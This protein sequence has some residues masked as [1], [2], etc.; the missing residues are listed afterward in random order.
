MRY[1]PL[2]KSE[3][4][5]IGTGHTVV[6]T[7]WTPKEAIAKK[8]DPEEYAAIGQ[9]YSPTRGINFLIRNLIYNPQVRYLVVLN[10]TKADANAGG[11]RSLLDFFCQGFSEGV[12]D[13]GKPCWVIQPRM[14]GFIDI[15]V[16]Y[17]VLIQLRKSIDLKECGDIKDAI[18]TVKEFSGYTSP[19]PWITPQQYPISEVKNS[20]LPGDRYGHRIE[21]STIAEAW[22]KLIHR[23]RTTG[24]I[25]PTGYD[26]KWQELINLLV[27]VTNEPDGFYFPE[28]NYLPTDPEFI[29]NYLPQI[30]EDA[31][32]EDGVKYTY[33]QR[34]RSWFH[35]D[36]IEDVIDKL[37]AE[38]DSASAVMNLWDS[39]RGFNNEISTAPFGREPGDSDHQHGG[40]PCLNHIWVRV[41]EGEL[42]LTGIFRSNDMFS[43]WPAN[44]M[45]LRSL[46]KHIRDEIANRSEYNLELGPLMILSQSAH[47]YD[48]CWEN[49]DKLISDQYKKNC[50]RQLLAFDDPCGNFIIQ[51]QGDEILVEQTN[52]MGEIVA[53]YS[54]CVGDSVEKAVKSLSHKIASANPGLQVHHAFYLGSE[55]QKVAIALSNKTPYLQDKSLTVA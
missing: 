14:K 48:D 54:E 13:N 50:Q 44:A 17:K 52:P 51:S 24:T 11:C 33:G 23:I 27:V 37:I 19:I 34:L 26:G 32:Y 20:I 45:G 1:N 31:P 42:S 25:R 9:L 55:L 46:Q 35:R 36:Q 7:G 53:T 16:P 29:K 10:G 18:A 6:V 12:N 43:A 8:L 3:Q 38:I 21:A 39:G 28:P 2:F 5:K 4:L 47:I 30:L 15:E 22:V 41:V 49:A 40:S